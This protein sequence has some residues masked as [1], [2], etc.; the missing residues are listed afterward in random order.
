MS[1]G[2]LA[3]IQRAALGQA[4]GTRK[5]I[6][7]QNAEVRNKLNQDSYGTS[8]QIGTLLQASIAINASSL[9]STE[10]IEKEANLKRPIP[11]P[12]FDAK[13]PSE[14][15]DLEDVV[16]GAE[17]DAIDLEG[18]LSVDSQKE[19]NQ[20][21]PYRRSSYIALKMRHLLPAIPTDSTS[22]GMTAHTPT[23]KDALRI[24][25][26]VHLSHLLAFRQAIQGKSDATIDQ[27]RVQTK[28]GEDFPPFLLE[29]LLERYTEVVRIGEEKRKSS[30]VMENKLLGYFL[31]LVLKIDGY[32][33]DV[34][35]I[36]NDLGIGS[37]KCVALLPYSFLRTTLTSPFVLTHRVQ[38]LFRSLGCTIVTPSSAERDRLVT[39]GQATS[40]NEAKKAKR[41]VLRVPLEFPRETRGMPKR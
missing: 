21:L 35:T 39:T 18:I 2:A 31:V 6:R 12:N 26:L 22:S 27:A 33:T 8:S 1:S 19:R 3:S 15:Y 14:V 13:T 11:P 28:L 36:A 9:P 34:G 10:G 29:Q 40:L 37:K 7:A 38:E 32:G 30:T 17:L 24:R 20:F 41:A 5:A 4:F 16:T 23:R 25:L